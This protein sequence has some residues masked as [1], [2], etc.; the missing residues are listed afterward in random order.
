MRQVLIV[1]NDAVFRAERRR[2]S[3]LPAIAH[4]QLPAHVSIQVGKRSRLFGGGPTR[5]GYVMQAGKA[6]GTIAVKVSDVKR[7]ALEVK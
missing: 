4:D 1:S 6:I 3:G 5:S 2:A 7:G